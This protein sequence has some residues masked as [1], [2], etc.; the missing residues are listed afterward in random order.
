MNNFNE[1]STNDRYFYR[2]GGGTRYRGKEIDMTNQERIAQIEEDGI[3]AK[4]K[5]ELL[6]HLEGRNVTQKQSIMAMC[7]DCMGYYA[8]GKQDC[9]VTS[10]P[11]HPFMP[12][13]EGG[14]RKLRVLGDEQK[15][16]LKANLHRAKDS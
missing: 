5:K 10:C 9:V 1:F 13:R 3:M 12:Y 11:L 7:Y 14:A 8:D 15:A 2:H 16:I 4:G 6:S